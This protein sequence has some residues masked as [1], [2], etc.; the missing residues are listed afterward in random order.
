MARWPLKERVSVRPPSDCMKETGSSEMP[1]SKPLWKVSM[2][3][4]ILGVRYASA[5]AWSG[6]GAEV[7]AKGVPH[8]LPT[9]ESRGWGDG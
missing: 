4:R 5:H 7:R 3:W 8:Q 1:A 6:W 2:Y 9:Y